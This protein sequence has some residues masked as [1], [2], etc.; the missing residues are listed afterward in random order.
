MGFFEDLFEGGHRRRMDHH[1]HHRSDDHLGYG[2]AYERQ[3]PPAPPAVT[4]CP[5]CRATLA[6][7]PG[8]RFCPECGGRL[9]SSSC[10]SCGMAAQPGAA[11]CQGCGAKL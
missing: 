6:L 5:S 9:G 8:F 10:R 3:T 11:F 4:A 1:D 7:A 2:H